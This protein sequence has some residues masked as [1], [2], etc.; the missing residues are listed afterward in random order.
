MFCKEDHSKMLGTLRHRVLLAADRRRRENRQ[1]RD[2]RNTISALQ[3]VTGMKPVELEA[4]ADRVQR[5]HASRSDRFF[6]VPVQ[7]AWVAIPVLL[8]AM[9]VWL[10]A[11]RL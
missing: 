3:E 5:E 11:I 4:I 1:K 9:T 8:A 2:L 10:T 7:I 6:S